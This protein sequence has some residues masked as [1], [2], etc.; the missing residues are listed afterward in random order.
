[1]KIIRNNT[2][3][4]LLCNSNNADK[5]TS[6]IVPASLL[7][8]VIGKKNKEH[9]YLFSNQPDELLDEYFGRDNKQKLFTEIKKPNFAYDFILCKKCETYFSEI[10]SIV[11]PILKYP[12][13]FLTQIK[14]NL[15][16]LNILNF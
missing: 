2:D 1:M 5:T 4:C 10:E 11:T 3:K 14:K 13:K 12:M 9:S 16:K 15:M 6:H 8:K 7:E